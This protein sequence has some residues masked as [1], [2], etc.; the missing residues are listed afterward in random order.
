MFEPGD[1]RHQEILDLADLAVGDRLR[2]AQR[3]RW[4]DLVTQLLGNIRS[5]GGMAEPGQ[6][7]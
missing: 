1:P 6:S 7:S 4:R 2:D 3:P 5:E